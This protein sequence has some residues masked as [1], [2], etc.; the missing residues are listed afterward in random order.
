M[1]AIFTLKDGRKIHIDTDVVLA[2][3]E[4]EGGSRIHSSGVSFEVKEA[5]KAVL[6]ELVEEEDDEDEDDED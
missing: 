3:E 5:A 1:F 2:V 4:L 6:E